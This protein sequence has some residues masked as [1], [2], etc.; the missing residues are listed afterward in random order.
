MPRLGKKGVNPGGTLSTQEVAKVLGVSHPT[1]LKL[2][3]AKKIP[4]PQVRGRVRYWNSSD[5]RHARVVLDELSAK[6]EI[7]L[8]RGGHG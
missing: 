6:G 7:R 5:V 3:K 1:L 4:E 8:S 2:M